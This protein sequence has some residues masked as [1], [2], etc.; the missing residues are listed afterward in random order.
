MPVGVALVGLATLVTVLVVTLSPLGTKVAHGNGPG[1]GGCI[2]PSG[3]ACTFKDTSASAEFGTVSDG[4]LF[5]TTDIQLF[6]S[7]TRPGASTSQAVVVSI[8]KFD[9]C[10][11][12]QLQAVTNV[13]P[14]TFLADF[15]GTLHFSSN[16]SMATVSGS[17]P[18]FDG[19]GNLLFTTTIN[20][21]WQGYG[22]TTRSIDSAHSHGAGMIVNTHFHGQTRSA[23]ASGTITDETGTNVA[24]LP[25]LTA[26]LTD[27]STG[28]VQ[29][30]QP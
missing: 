19:N 2:A 12:I 13:N 24:T 7:L 21:T 25:T 10:Q 14:T 28:T 4:C 26:E 15:T 20:V 16:L 29:I 9:N 27:A 3:P 5:T 1:S 18:M 23:E 6:D 17:A 8:T 22:P 30:T 11:N